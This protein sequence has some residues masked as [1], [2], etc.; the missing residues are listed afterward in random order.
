MRL[1]LSVISGFIGVYSFLCLIRVFLSWF[2]SN[3]L[4]GPFYMLCRICDPYLNWFSRFNFL[5]IGMF[6]FS[7]IVALAILQVAQSI[8]DRLSAWGHVSA[9]FVGVLL[10]SAVWSALSFILGFM[11]IVLV[12]RFLG[13]AFHATMSPFWR[14]V[15]SICQG[16]IYQAQRIVFRGRGSYAASMVAAIL[17]FGVCW[18]GGRVLVNMA[19]GLLLS[20]SAFMM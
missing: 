13:Y 9:G 18:L 6:D 7:P 11:F 17:F 8:V 16:V 10:L 12:I 1:V 4:G 20:P 3:A 5:R 15:D 19:Y 2:S 14:I